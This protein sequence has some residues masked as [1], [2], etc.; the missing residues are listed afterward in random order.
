MIQQNEINPQNTFTIEKAEKW[1]QER[2]KRSKRIA[3]RNKLFIPIYTKKSIA[4][5]SEH[6]PV[7]Q[8]SKFQVLNFKLNKRQ[9]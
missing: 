1:D 3:T 9:A 2:K 4:Q 6:I 5:K 8:I 7:I